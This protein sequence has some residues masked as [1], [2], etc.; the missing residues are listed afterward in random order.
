MALAG[1]QNISLLNKMYRYR[2]AAFGDIGLTPRPH[3]TIVC[4]YRHRHKNIAADIDQHGK[5]RRER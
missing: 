3:H 1:E 5:N 2:L 4:R